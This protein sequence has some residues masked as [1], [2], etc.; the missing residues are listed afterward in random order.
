MTD[1]IAIL[2]T[3]TNPGA[4]SRSSLWKRW[5][6]NWIAGFEGAAGAPRIVAAAMS[7][8]VAGA[9][10]LRNC[11]PT[12]SLDARSATSATERVEVEAS[13]ATALVACA[14]R[15]TI[16]C[17]R[18]VG[19]SCNASLIVYKNG[20]AVQ[21]Y[22]TSLTLA[23]LDIS[24]AAGDAFGIVLTAQGTSGGAAGLMTLTACTIS[25][26]K[27]SVVLI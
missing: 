20:V 10:V 2:E 14:V 1:Y 16:S 27:R 24:L 8:T 4:P 15:F 7:G 26:D 12:G 18:V 5:A 13:K 3:E 9:V 17:T 23:T 22:V 11:L 6:N 21:T 19:S 25:A